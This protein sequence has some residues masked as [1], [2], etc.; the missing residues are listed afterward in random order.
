MQQVL[1]PFPWYHRMRE[2]QPV[3]YEAQQGV[4][5]VFRYSDVERVLTDHVT[6][7]SQVSSPSQEHPLGVSLISLDPPRHRQLRS[8]VAQGFTPRMV[9]QLTPRITAIVHNLLDQVA[10]TGTMDIID[11]LA[12]PLP[13]IVMAEL[14]G[15][16]TGEWTRFT[17]ISDNT[18]GAV[19][20]QQAE[21]IDYLLNVIEQRHL[22]PKD[23][24]ISTLLAE[25]VDGQRLNRRELLG[26]C[27]LLIAA[28]TQPVTNLIGN[29][30][31][32]FDERPEVMEHLRNRP[33]LLPGA[34]EE[35]L[36]YLSPV[37]FM[38]RMSATATSVGGQEI[39]AT[40]VVIAHIGSA[41]R[42][43]MVFIQAD[44][45]DI[46][47]F[48]NHHLAF[49]HGIHYCLGASLARLE[50]RIVLEALLE[51]LPDLKRIRNV[52]LERMENSFIYGI[53]HLP[54]MF[55]VQKTY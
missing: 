31:L 15:I 40:Q 26:F 16:P 2:S 42:D 27:A 24:L 54:V 9:T 7:S 32:C 10:S 23:D 8:L 34:I 52:P 5:I 30:M 17:S 46:Q 43:E 19:H 12:Q 33:S 4:W 14:L 50:A 55:K 49:G 36:R 20:D 6:F 25:Q 22:Q 28:G 47:R 44:R 38:P 37:Q 13:L 29:A 45:F 39:K 21:M 3:I 35:V 53:K 51:R 1:N 48:P 41:N 11:D 18:G